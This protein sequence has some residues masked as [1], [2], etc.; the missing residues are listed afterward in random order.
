MVIEELLVILISVDRDR[1][2]ID[3][4]SESRLRSC[5]DR[6]EIDPR[7]TRDRPEIRDPTEIVSRSTQDR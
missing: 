6:P 1:L 2:E 3:P 7:S 5:R 4:R